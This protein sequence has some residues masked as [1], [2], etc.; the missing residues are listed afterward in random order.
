MANDFASGTTRFL[1]AFL[2]LARGVVAGPA[3]LGQT[4][5]TLTVPAKALPSGCALQQPAPGPAP[6]SSGGVA[7]TSRRVWSPF[8][9]NPWSGTERW[10]VAVVSK[11]IDGTPRAVPDG[12][13]LD[14]RAAAAFELK[15]ADNIVEA[16]HATYSSAN[17][18]EVE[19][20][21]VRFND[22]K[23]ATPESL[24]EMAGRQRRATRRIVRGAT[25]IRLSAPTPTECFA[26]VRAYIESLK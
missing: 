4:V 26:A 10:I 16:Y 19:V 25:V 2:L 21:G 18:S 7:V 17:G 11:A 5:N 20:F 14:A 12:P 8:T 6:T 3:Q 13:P 22:V 24:S 15:W 1:V 9:T 23:L